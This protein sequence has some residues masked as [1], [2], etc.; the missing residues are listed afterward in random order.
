MRSIWCSDI[1]A[2]WSWREETAV[3]RVV[4]TGAGGLVARA[5]IPALEGA[6]HDVLP[7]KRADADITDLAGLRH[8]LASFKPEWIV[9][10]AAYTQVDDAETHADHAY[11]VNA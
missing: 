4:L 11:L 7:L 6:G 5:L 8:P 3:V 1:R 2:G 9:N 10:L